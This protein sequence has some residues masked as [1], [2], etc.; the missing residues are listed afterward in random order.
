MLVVS[1]GIID[2]SVQKFLTQGGFRSE[3]H[4]E[5]LRLWS[6]DSMKRTRMRTCGQVRWNRQLL[7]EGG[8]DNEDKGE[9]AQGRE[10]VNR[11]KDEFPVWLSAYYSTRNNSSIDP[12]GKNGDLITNVV[13]NVGGAYMTFLQRGK[14]TILR[15]PLDRSA[16]KWRLLNEEDVI[17]RGNWDWVNL[18]VLQKS[19]ENVRWM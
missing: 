4:D 17:E 19:F 6:V 12:L 14:W 10:E 11:T 2:K 3:N 18:S 9:G 13:N 5:G 15:D 16:E 7:D 1:N 8:V